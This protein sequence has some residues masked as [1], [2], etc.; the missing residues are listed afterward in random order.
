MFI[1]NIAK[2]KKI[3]VNIHYLQRIFS[4]KIDYFLQFSM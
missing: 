1:I 4:K 3:M 2:I